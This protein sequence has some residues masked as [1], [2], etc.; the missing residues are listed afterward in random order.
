M[1]YSQQQEQMELEAR[2]TAAVVAEAK[3]WRGVMPILNDR[4]LYRTVEAVNDYLDRN[5]LIVRMV[6]VDP[7]TCAGQAATGYPARGESTGVA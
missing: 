3:Q 5:H 7:S 2:L 4:D 1:R 6:V